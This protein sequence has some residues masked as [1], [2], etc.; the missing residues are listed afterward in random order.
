MFVLC[1]RF[2][3]DLIRQ[4]CADMYLNRDEKSFSISLNKNAKKSANNSTETNDSIL[5]QKFPASLNVMNI[6]DTIKKHEKFDFLTNKYM[7]IATASPL[8]SSN[9]DVNLGQTDQLYSN[10]NINKNNNNTNNINNNNTNKVLTI[11]K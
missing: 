1:K 9:P 7:A 2:A 6:F 10:S 3:D 11:F 8:K 5:N 4:T